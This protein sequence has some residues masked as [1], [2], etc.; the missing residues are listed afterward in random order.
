MSVP[1]CN[2]H[3][4]ARGFRPLLPGRP[5]QGRPVRR[6]VRHRRPDHQDLLQAQLSGPAP[7]RPQHAVLPHRGG[8]AAGRLPGLQALP[9]GRLPGLPRVERARRRGRPGDAADRRRH[10]RPRGGDRPRRP[11]RLHHAPA[12]AAC[13]R[14]R[15]APNP[16]ALARAQRAQTAR[17]LIETTDLP[18]G[19]VAFAAGFSSIRQFND[20]VRAVCDLTPTALR[21]RAQAKFGRGETVPAGALSLR[22]P[23]RT[24]FAYEGLFGH[25]A[26]CAVPGVEEVRDGAYR[27]T[28]RLPAAAAS[29][30]SHTATRPRASA[31][32]C[33]TT[34]A[35]SP[36]RSPAAAG[37][38]TSTPTPK[39]SSTRSA[40]TPIWRPGREGT[41]AAH[42]AHRRRARTRPPRRAR[43]A[44]V[45]QGRPHP[46]RAH[47]RRVRQ[48]GDRYRR[49]A[50]AR[51][52]GDRAPRRDR[53]GP[54]GLP[55]VAAAIP[56]RA[57]RGVGQRRRHCWMP[58]ATG[59]A[60]EPQLLALPGIGPWTAEVIAMR[61]LGDPDA[62]PATD[63]GVLL[64]AKQVGLPEDSRALTEH[65]ARWR[66]WRSYA[67]QHLW[68][69]LDH[70]VNQWPPKE[71]MMSS[72][73]ISHRRQPGRAAHPGRTR[74]PTDASAHGRPDL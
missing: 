51:L 35:T 18:F 55:E 61:G 62:F 56:D 72:H 33:S 59:T 19:D 48:A 49:R 15:S 43:P 31:R 40:P 25:L 17:V 39:P 57:R 50:D 10:R 2:C 45:G 32:S 23:V 58:A 12:R 46:R 16:L 1:R 73:P 74:W 70:A 42:P 36:P 22:L 41:R 11:R 54:F 4:C 3:R 24:P 21:R 30:T 13:C 27:R 66:P 34:S 14:P 44:G 20:T 67:A 5:V 37:C 8:G 60:P 38:S 68:T 53:P 28:L 6:L 52:P 63:L 47:R 65:S 69:A 71:K 29:S 26:A 7:V 9:P 64:A